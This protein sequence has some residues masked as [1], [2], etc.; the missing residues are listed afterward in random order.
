M[1]YTIPLPSTCIDRA[2]SI[3]SNA[4]FVLRFWKSIIVNFILIHQ[5]SI[6]ILSISCINRSMM[7]IGFIHNLPSSSLYS[8]SSN[9]FS[10]DTSVLTLTHPLNTVQIMVFK[11]LILYENM[12]LLYSIDYCELSSGDIYPDGSITLVF[13]DTFHK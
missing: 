8:L 6:Y 7:S 5:S 1:V 9:T 4:C 13:L 3:T 10:S 11:F 2:V 12:Y